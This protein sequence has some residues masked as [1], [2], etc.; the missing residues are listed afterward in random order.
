MSGGEKPA[1]GLVLERLAQT[2]ESRKGADPSSSYTAS[3][4]AKGPSGCAR[5]FGEEAVETVIAALEGDGA[6]L[7]GEAADALFHL[8][9]VLTA[10]GVSPGEVAKVLADREGVSGHA[11]KAARKND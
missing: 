3:L 5:K 2:I 11:E 4:L 6:A 8:L 9:V 7:A 1:L 10:A